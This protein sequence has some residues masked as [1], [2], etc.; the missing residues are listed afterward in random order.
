MLALRQGAG[1]FGAAPARQR[2]QHHGH[3]GGGGAGQVPGQ[4]PGPADGGFQ[5]HRAVIKGA[6]VTVGCGAGPL[7]H[8]LRQS[9][10]IAE[11]CP[12][13]GGGQQ[14]RVRVRAAVFGQLIGPLTQRPGPGDGQLPG[15]QRGGDQRMR[16][17]AA[18][19]LH[20]RTSGTVGDVGEGPQPG[21]G[22]V[23][24]I[25]LMALLGTERGQHLRPRRRVL[26]LGLLQPDQRL[27]LHRRPQPSGIT[28]GQVTQP[29]PHHGQ[30]LHRDS[31]AQQA[32]SGC[33]WTGSPP[34]RDRLGPAT[35]SSSITSSMLEEIWRKQQRYSTGSAGYPQ[36]R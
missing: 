8:L 15:A 16:G 6:L 29:G 27:R 26:R 13:V 31:T 30:R 3:G 18:G 33:T 5:P 14:D 4:P 28:G 23:L 9:G 25:S 12:A 32:Q 19:P 2:V 34:L 21:R 11:L 17:Q 7:D 1:I 20:G 10:Q 22:P 35:F 36:R 24:P